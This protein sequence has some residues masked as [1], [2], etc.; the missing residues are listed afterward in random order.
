MKPR[1]SRWDE[2]ALCHARMDKAEIAAAQPPEPEPT[3]LECYKLMT[4][5]TTCGEMLDLIKQ[6]RAT[7]ALT[8][9]CRRRNPRSPKCAAPRRHSLPDDDASGVPIESGSGRSEEP[10]GRDCRH[11][12]RSGVSR[13]GAR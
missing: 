4:Q 12:R 1:P 2:C 6:L 5:A 8:A 10:S 9:R 7:G 3:C 11:F 13:Q